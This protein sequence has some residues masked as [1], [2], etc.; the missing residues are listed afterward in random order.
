MRYHPIENYGIIGNMHSAALVSLDGSVDWLCL[1][2]FDSPS[3]FGAILDAEKGGRFRIA[4][5]AS[6]VLP[7]GAFGKSAVAI[8]S[9]TTP[10]VV[11][12]TETLL[13]DA[14]ATKIRSSFGWTAIWLGCSPTV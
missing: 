12:I 11:E 6:G 13:L 10:R 4:P 5:T 14:F 8:V 3:V 1:P 2:R 9:I 7:S